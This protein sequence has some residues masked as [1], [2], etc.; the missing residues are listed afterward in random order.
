MI[1]N[2]NNKFDLNKE[3]S[4]SSQD[5][6]NVRENHDEFFHS[7]NMNDDFKGKAKDINFHGDCGADGLGSETKEYHGKKGDFWLAGY[8]KK[9]Q[10]FKSKDVLKLTVEIYAM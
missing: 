1:E 9:E 2:R 6:C 7:S 5:D 3:P 8:I 4:N 10:V